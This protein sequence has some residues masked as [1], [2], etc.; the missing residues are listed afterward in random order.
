MRRKKRIQNNKQQSYSCW[1]SPLLLRNFANTASKLEF[2]IQTPGAPCFIPN[3]LENH[4]KAAY[5]LSTQRYS[6]LM[7]NTK[8]FK[9]ERVL[10]MSLSS[11]DNCF[12]QHFLLEKCNTHCPTHSMAAYKFW[13]KAIKNKW[14]LVLLI[15]ISLQKKSLYNIMSKSDAIICNITMR[16][17][18]S[19]NQYKSNMLKISF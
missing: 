2:K 12:K 14:H 13:F 11:L 18:S 15:T 8:C 4:F 17:R 3:M 10:W 16:T 19:E 5:L 7:S 6:C 1:N 9:Y